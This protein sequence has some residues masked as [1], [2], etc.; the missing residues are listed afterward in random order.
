VGSE[1]ESARKLA[2]EL[3]RATGT[4]T[5][6]Y[7]KLWRCVCVGS[8][9]ET[10]RNLA[11]LNEL[12]SAKQ[13]IDRR[14][15]CRHDSVGLVVND[16]PVST[17]VFASS[18]CCVPFETARKVANASVGAEFV[19]AGKLTGELISTR[20]QIIPRPD[21]TRLSTHECGG[22]EGWCECVC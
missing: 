8:E 12:E 13:Y 5:V 4:T 18:A 1:F 14:R 15:Q 2:S 19:R 17:A 16:P 7:E 3:F 20:S 22:G 9:F 11:S 21:N 10:L 6:T